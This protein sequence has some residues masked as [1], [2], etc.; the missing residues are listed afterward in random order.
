MVKASV[1]VLLKVLTLVE[2]S[3]RVSMAEL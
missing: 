1:K 2:L 3:V